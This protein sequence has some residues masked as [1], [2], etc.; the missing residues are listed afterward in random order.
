[1]AL[2]GVDISQ[3]QGTIN[4]D[5]L[6]AVANFVIIRSS[7]GTITDPEFARNQSEARR[8]RAQAGPLGIGYYY[9]A[10]PE[11]LGAD[12]SARYFVANLG[13]LQ[14]G[15][16]LFLDLEGSIGTAPVAWSLVWLQ[17]VL[18]L[19][20]TKP[21]VYLNQS[22]MNSLDW[23][24]VINEGY[25]LWIADYDGNQTSL[26]PNGKWSVAAIKQWTDV[27]IV[28]GIAGKVDGDT[29]EGDFSAWSAYG[30]HAPAVPST[31]L[32]PPAP[33]PV[34]VAT[35]PPPLSVEP[36]KPP[37]VVPISVPPVVIP[38]HVTPNHKGSSLMQ[39]T[40]FYVALAG[41]AVQFLSSL[42]G[43]SSVYTTLAIGLL[44]AIGVYSATNTAKP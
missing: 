4:W 24:P 23:Q 11:L 38:T 17:T 42:Y 13:P 7:Y 27:D 37:T 35:P 43:V 8:V 21:L 9:F 36:S 22:E 28:S 31:P 18:A 10:Y 20:G 3:F 34:V 33:T 26:G 15:E 5:Q 30:Y 1:M 40:K 44:T 19:T 6:N 25:G 39:Y 29:F 14:D 41:A 2:Y 16:V 12:E 32:V